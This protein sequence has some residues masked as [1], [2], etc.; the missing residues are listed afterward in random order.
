MVV[1]VVVVVVVVAVVIVVVFH[2]YR[3]GVSTVTK[4]P[5]KTAGEVSS[6]SHSKMNS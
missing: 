5:P 3:H 4:A 6:P 2:S 1:V